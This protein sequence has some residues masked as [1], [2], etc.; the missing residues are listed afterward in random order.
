MLYYTGLLASSIGDTNKRD[1][2][3]N[4]LLKISDENS[5][6]RVGVAEAYYFDRKYERSLE[7]LSKVNP[8]SLNKNLYYYTLQGMNYFMLKEY[9]KTIEKY[10]Y[11][12]SIDT[13]FNNYTT[14][15]MLGEVYDIMGNADSAIYYYELHYAIDKENTYLLN[16]Y[17]YALSKEGKELEKASEMSKKTLELFPENS[18]FLDTYGW[19]QYKLGNYEEAKKYIEKAIEIGGISAEVYE[20]LGDVYVELGEKEKARTMYEKALELE[21]NRFKIE[22]KIKI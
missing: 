14:L 20:H 16:N 6:L 11:V 19:I 7:V 13:A 12:L 21:K 22:D 10:K 2:F 17:A 5:D 1:T 9:Q 18:A 8:D 3:F 4:K 15:T